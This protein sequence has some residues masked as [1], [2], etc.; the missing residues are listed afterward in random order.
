MKKI[1]FLILLF[2]IAKFSYTQVGIGTNSPNNQSILE[3][4][5][6]NKGLLFPR[7]NSAQMNAIASPPNGLTIYNTD[8]A[9][10]CVYA[11]GSWKNVCRVNS[12]AQLKLSNDSLFVVNSNFVKLPVKDSQIYWKINGNFGNT[13]NHYFGTADTQAIRIKVNQKNSGFISNASG[14]NTFFGYLTADSVTGNNNSAFGHTALQNVKTG[15]RNTAMGFEAAKNTTTGSSNISIGALSLHSNRAGN[16]GIAIGDE[17]MRYINNTNVNFNNLSLAIGYNALRG[18]TTPS[19]N[20]GV[21]NMAI[22][23]QSLMNN[24]TGYSNVA[25]GLNSMF[26]NTGGYSNCGIGEAAL[27]GNT[28]GIHNFA[29]G[30]QSLTANTGSYNTAIGSLSMSSNTSGG[31]NT[32]VGYESLTKNTTGIRNVSI[33]SYSLNINVVGSEN[34]AVGYYACR[35]VRNDGNI[36]IGSRALYDQTNGG[37]NTFVGFNS[38]FYYVNSAGG[39]AFGALALHYGYSTNTSFL[40]TNTAIGYESIRGSTVAANNSGLGNSALGFASMKFNSSGDSCTAIGQY[41][42]T[43]NTTGDLNT[44]LGSFSLIANTTGQGNTA[45]GNKTLTRITTGNYNLAIGNSANTTANNLKHASAIGSF[46]TVSS[47]NTMAF[48]RADSVNRWCFGRANVGSGVFQVG[49]GTADGNGAYL[50][51]GGTWTNASDSNVKDNISYLNS[52]DIL[53]KVNQLKISKWSYKKTNEFHIG[54]MAQQFAQLFNVGENHTSI[55]TID[56]AGVALVAIQQLSRE[57]ETMKK[58]I[59]ELKLMLEKLSQNMENGEAKK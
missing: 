19:A 24:T 17:A 38:G 7:L 42:L 28:S 6:T 3:L 11:S 22:G 49:S 15:A 36:G 41:A 33:G 35:N 21:Q 50:T 37:Y 34:V 16:R 57:N 47:S 8:S 1:L 39:T 48:G 9:C 18:G 25:V 2:T 10:I 51:A 59:A 46:A 12:I 54:P 52:A 53:Q 26:S 44:A 13:A 4:N 58:E 45:L 27:Y 23:Y 20:S 29:G 14:S 5:S 30:Y 55:S 40:N 31:S 43:A 32:A 56:P